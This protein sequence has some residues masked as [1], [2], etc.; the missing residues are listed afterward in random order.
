MVYAVD[1]IN[2]LL[3]GYILLI[4]ARAVLPWLP[5]GRFN[6]AVRLVYSATDPVIQPIRKGIPPSF[7]GIDA[8]PFVAIVLI[9][10][11]QQVIISLL[12]AIIL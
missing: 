4:V 11:L 8:A 12:T 7:V 5:I 2:W 9:W 10:I 1:I 3:H 6:T